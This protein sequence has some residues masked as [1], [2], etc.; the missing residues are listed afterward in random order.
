MILGLERWAGSDTPALLDDGKETWLSYRELA[1]AV[2]DCAA[3]IARLNHPVVFLF[4]MNDIPSAV[5][6]LGCLEAGAPVAPLRADLAMEK[7]RGLVDLYRPG[8]VCGIDP[9]P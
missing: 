7:A 4:G 8:V 1:T 3:R 2:T 6:Y 9:G 5:I